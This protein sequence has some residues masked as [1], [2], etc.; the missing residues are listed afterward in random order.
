[1]KMT[2][3]EALEIIKKYDDY[4][5]ARSL[6][7]N[8]LSPKSMGSPSKEE[9]DEAVKVVEEDLDKLDQLKSIEKELGI[10]LITLYKAFRYGIYVKK[11]KHNGFVAP[12]D[13]K[14]RLG[15]QRIVDFANK[16]EYSRPYEVRLIFGKTGI[17]LSSLS[18]GKDWALTKEELENDIKNI[19]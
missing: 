14:G 9:F 5:M 13:L 15:W 11:G 6:F 3:K 2:S 7:H 1:M 19:K 4:V 17:C 10:D 18:Y 16:E 8:V 12:Q